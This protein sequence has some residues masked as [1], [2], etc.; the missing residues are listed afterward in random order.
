MRYQLPISSTQV[1]SRPASTARLLNCYAEKLPDGARSPVMLTRTAG[2]HAWST[3]GIGPIYATHAAFGKL[4]VVSATKLYE[5]DENK[6]ATELGDIGTIVNV[7]I[8]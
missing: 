2:V 5:V 3:V 8:D 6:N 7:D 1:R 4:Y